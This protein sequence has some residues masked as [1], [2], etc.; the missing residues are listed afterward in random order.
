MTATT[1]DCS[2]LI[3]QHPGTPPEET[4]YQQ[5][6]P[7]AACEY[8]QRHSPRSHDFFSFWT[9]QALQDRHWGWIKTLRSF[10]PSPSNF[11]EHVFKHLI[12]HQ[13]EQALH[14]AFEQGGC[15]LGLATGAFLTHCIQSDSIKGVEWVLGTQ[16]MDTI[17][18]QALKKAIGECVC[19]HPAEAAG[20]EHR[21][22]LLTPL[23]EAYQ[24]HS[25]DTLEKDLETF[26]LYA[27]EFSYIPLAHCIW[28]F[29]PE[30][31]RADPEWVAF[32]VLDRT[33]QLL[34]QSLDDN[35][36]VLVQEDPVNFDVRGFLNLKKNPAAPPMR[37]FW[38][39][40]LLGWPTQVHA[41]WDHLKAKKEQGLLEWALTVWEKIPPSLY[42]KEQP[43]MNKLLITLQEQ[44]IFEGLVSAK[45]PQAE[46]SRAHGLKI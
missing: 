31:R 33:G 37:L 8:I 40:V 9:A 32:G 22:D 21:P 7:M 17:P 1:H 26:W 2:E 24:R 12:K 23:L 25:P 41:I 34:Q 44:L 11:D 36:P 30:A 6:D 43:A 5:A 27:V 13:Q 45:A 19:R 18:A 3:D 15:R 14:E 29:F 20:F 4:L 46:S 35:Q 38:A 28:A 39:A 16:P 42:L 10:V